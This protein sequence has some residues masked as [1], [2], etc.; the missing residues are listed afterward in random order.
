MHR[1]VIAF[2][3]IILIVSSSSILSEITP[4]TSMVNHTHILTAEK[5]TL[6]MYEI[7]GLIMF[8]FSRENDELPTTYPLGSWEYLQWYNEYLHTQNI[9]CLIYDPNSE[10]AMM[11]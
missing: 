11:W 5:C 3:V 6:S 9:E 1:M 7:D 4:V 2:C 8:V 10:K